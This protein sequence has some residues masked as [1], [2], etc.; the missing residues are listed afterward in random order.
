MIEK[1]SSTPPE[2]SLVEEYLDA[3]DDQARDEFL[4]SHQE[5]ITQEFLDLLA[6]FAMQVQSSEDK[7]MAEH[8]IAANRQA[9]R[10]SMLLKMQAG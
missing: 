5:H 2:L 10:F 7:Q 1:S 9:T 4:S 8:V 3:K 6:N